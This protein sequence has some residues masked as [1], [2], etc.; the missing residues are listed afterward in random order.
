MK[1]S[2]LG[3]L[4]CS[5][6]L[7]FPSCLKKQDLHNEDLG[8][9]VAAIEVTKALGQGF[10]SYDFNEIKKNEFTSLLLTQKIQDSVT[11]SIE[12]QGIT[13][14]TAMN[15]VDKLELD[16]IVQDEI[17]SNGQT[18]QSTRKWPIVI[19][20]SSQ[21]T[22]EE[23]G[24]MALERTAHTMSDAQSPMLTF[25]MFET[26]A[27]GSC[28]DEGKY[29]E[30]CHQLKSFDIRFKVPLAAAN[31]HNCVDIM[32]CYIPAKQVEFDIVRKYQLDQDGNPKRTHY[33]VL[34]SPSVPFLSRVLQ[35]CSRS[36]YEITNS[37]QKI[38]ADICYSVNNY[39]AGTPTA[40][41]A[42][43]SEK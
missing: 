20:K 40:A 36:V 17:Y 13:V 11:Q 42:I 14:E 32:N 34:L 15:S 28:F 27:F 6:A 23:V 18:S 19:N 43:S 30:T 16:L 29:P 24:R 12:Q 1:K 39:A 7:A 2:D 26:L 35:L 31:Q 10:G 4:F 38:L 8:P 3:L 5:L 21:S 25:L 41:T 37:N 33:T 22:A 9:A